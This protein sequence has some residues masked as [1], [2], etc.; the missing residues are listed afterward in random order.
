MEYILRENI[1][2]NTI[3]GIFKGNLKDTVADLLSTSKISKDMKNLPQSADIWHN[4]E[5]VATLA[6]ANKISGKRSG[7]VANAHIIFSQKEVDA[8]RNETGIDYLKDSKKAVALMKRYSAFTVM[9]AS[10]AGQR[11]YIMDDQDN[12]SWNVVP[13]SALTG[14]DSG[15]QL[16]AALTKMMRL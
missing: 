15:D 13:Y 5:K 16:N 10:D 9:I 11:V 12:I 7:N 14:K 6:A 3:E 2:G 1:E 8:V 4:L